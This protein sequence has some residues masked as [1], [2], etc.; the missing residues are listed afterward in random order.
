MLQ[1]KNIHSLVRTL[2]HHTSSVD[3]LVQWVAALVSS[4]ESMRIFALPLT[5]LVNVRAVGHL[6]IGVKRAG[7]RCYVARR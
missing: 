2:S 6:W 4:E 3:V 1:P 7:V 5:R